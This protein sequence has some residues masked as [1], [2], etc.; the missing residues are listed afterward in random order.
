MTAYFLPRARPAAWMC[1]MIASGSSALELCPCSD[2]MTSCPPG[3]EGTG[4]GGSARVAS[5]IGAGAGSS[6]AH[7][8]RKRVRIVFPVIWTA[9]SY[10]SS[11][12]PPG[13][14]GAGRL[15]GRCGGSSSPDTAIQPIWSRA[16]PRIE[17]GPRSAHATL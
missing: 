11:T 14:A 6:T 17:A 1:G 10:C 13:R 7:E 12:G 2:R 3:T 5:G 9:I 15:T 8:M 4:S 16:A